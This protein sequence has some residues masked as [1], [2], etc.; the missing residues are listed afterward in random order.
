MPLEFLAAADDLNWGATPVPPVEQYS[1]GWPVYETLLAKDRIAHC[2]L[3]CRGPRF[4][5][6]AVLNESLVEW[7]T[8]EGWPR[9]DRPVTIVRS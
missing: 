1:D 2:E 3:F 4:D 6:E 5:P 7:Y 8:D 9:G